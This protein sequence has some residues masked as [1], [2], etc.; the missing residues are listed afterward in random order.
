MIPATIEGVRLPKGVLEGDQPPRSYTICVEDS[1]DKMLRGRRFLKARK[2]HEER[3]IHEAD[4]REKDLDTMD[5]DVWLEN[6]QRRSLGCHGLSMYGRE[7]APISILK[8]AG[9]VS[10]TK[11]VSF[12]TPIEWVPQVP[13][14]N[15]KV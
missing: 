2:L 10:R 15:P 13:R 7:K 9:H 1:G 14:R 3:S 5:R 6:S 4:P 11:S 12:D 8:R